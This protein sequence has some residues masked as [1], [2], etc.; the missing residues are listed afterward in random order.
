[1]GYNPLSIK[2]VQFS[3]KDP[4]F[5]L[6]P[7]GIPPQLQITLKELLINSYTP[8]MVKQFLVKENVELIGTFEKFLTDL[9]TVSDESLEAEHG[10]GFWIDHWTYNLDLIDSYL[11]V[12]PDRKNE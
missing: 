7:Y 1:D 10:D 4:Q 2:T 12:Y 5:D 6:N 9:L 3:L 8:G 11:A